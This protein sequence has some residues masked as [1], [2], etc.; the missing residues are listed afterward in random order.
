MDTAKIFFV[1]ESTLMER[2]IPERLEI[3][4]R[5]TL[6]DISR[7]EFL[8]YGCHDAF[9]YQALTIVGQ[10]K[11]EYPEKQLIVMSII[12]P[13]LAEKGTDAVSPGI[14]RRSMKLP[15]DADQKVYAPEFPLKSD[16]QVLRH[17][18]SIVKWAISK[19][20]ILFTYYY[21]NL[22]SPACR[23]AE[24]A[25]KKAGADIHHLY[26]TATYER[27]NELII[28]LPD[29]QR[30]VLDMVN[31]GMTYSDAGRSLDVS[32]NRAQQ[33]AAQGAR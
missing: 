5:K 17:N 33:N 12:D 14:F 6:S 19:C 29:R 26:I 31:E 3:E 11:K 8:F 27:I 7:A 21:S 13:V 20:N 32:G 23:L 30:A 10:L 22:P 16:K 18:R 2:G 4:L 25:A 15:Y 24:N 1:G 9:T 28:I